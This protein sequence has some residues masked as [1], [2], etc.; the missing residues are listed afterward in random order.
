M[1][2]LADN[3]REIAISSGFQEILSPVLSSRKNMQEKMDLPDSSDIVEIENV[4]S[5]TYSAVRNRLAP[6]LLEVLSKNKHN[7]FPQK[8]FEE[9]V[10]NIREGRAVIQRERIA[11]AVFSWQ[12]GFCGCQAG[13]GFFHE[14]FGGVL[15]GQEKF[16][17]FFY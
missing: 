14:Q 5:E 9:G 1:S 15:F 13:S 6:V 3:A 10:V 16:K 7:D 11:F 12:G 2:L 8:I 4:M 17:P